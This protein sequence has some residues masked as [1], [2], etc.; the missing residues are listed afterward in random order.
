MAELD[1]DDTLATEELAMSTQPKDAIAMLIA[2]HKKVKSLFEEFA[3]LGDRAKVSKKKLADQICHEL[4]V[5]T[6]LEEELF[7]PTV[8]PPIKDGD[9]M[10]EALV[11]HACAKGLIAEI[12]AMQP[13]DDLYDAKMT[14]LSE[15]I[16]H[17]VREEEDDMFEKARKTKVDLVKL[18]EQMAE[19]KMQIEAVAV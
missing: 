18:G 2:D 5:H 3:A 9:L 12:M 7:Y 1:D 4:T 15:Q 6:Q 16:D 13:G 19:L 17:H 10:D 8:R 14:V 11:E